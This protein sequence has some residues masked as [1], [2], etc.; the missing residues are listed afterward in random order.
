MNFF[1]GN[2]RFQANRISSRADGLHAATWLGNGQPRV[3]LWKTE[4][5][6]RTVNL[7]TYTPPIL[8]ELSDR[9]SMTV[10]ALDSSATPIFFT[11]YGLSDFRVLSQLTVGD[12]TCRYGA[13][14]RLTTGVPVFVT[15]RDVKVPWSDP[16]TG[17][18]YMC[19]DGLVHLD[20]T[21]CRAGVWATANFS[22]PQENGLLDRNG[23]HIMASTFAMAEGADGLAYLFFTN[24]SSGAVH[25]VRF[26]ISTTKIEMIDHWGVPTPPEWSISGEMPGITAV[27]DLA[28]GRIILGYQS[29]ESLYPPKCQQMGIVYV[30]SASTVLVAIYPDKRLQPLARLPWEN[31]HDPNIVVVGWQ[32]PDGLYYLTT[33]V[34]RENACTGGLRRGQQGGWITIDANKSFRAYSAT[35]WTITQYPIPNNPRGDSN[36]ELTQ[37][38][39]HST[40]APIN[41]HLEDAISEVSVFITWT[42]RKTADCVEVSTDGGVSWKQCFYYAPL[43]FS[44]G[45]EVRM[46]V[47][48]S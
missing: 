26:R 13:S 28:G 19:S 39:F 31:H 7:P 2:A 12:N 37:I 21:V 48:R 38:N 18:K 25:C 23:K 4:T 9:E 16:V 22:F 24:D 41:Y 30:T 8:G 29:T 15:S 45:N 6:V 5:D 47:K 40:P 33:Y 17:I 14:C 20:A 42:D 32:K 44:T 11:E 35:G 36:F 3:S 27:S 34:D 46:R 43:Q 10:A 1:T